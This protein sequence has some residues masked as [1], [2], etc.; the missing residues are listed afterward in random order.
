MSCVDTE[1]LSSLFLLPTPRLPPYPSWAQ[2]IKDCSVHEGEP[3][4]GT[5][6][7]LYFQAIEL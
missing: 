2:G 5:H 6:P 1:F 7:H 3:E 4:K